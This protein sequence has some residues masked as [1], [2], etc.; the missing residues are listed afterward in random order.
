[1][2]FKIT[3]KKSILKDL[4]FLCLGLILGV[5]L[6]KY[7]LPHIIT[8]SN[9]AV[10]EGGYNFINPLLSCN[11]SEDKQFSSYK[12]IEDKL[13]TYI[14]QNIKNGDA[15]NISVY[16][17]GLNS[18]HWSGVGE[19]NTYAPAS[20]LK[21]PLMIAYLKEADDNPDILKQKLTYTQTTDE[22]TA[23]YFKPQKF[24][25]P[26][27]SYTVDDLL[28]YMI[29][30]SDNNAATLLQNNLKQSDLLEVYSDIGIPVSSNLTDENM[31]PKIYSYIFRILYNATYLSKPM[32]QYALEL[33]SYADF[34]QGLESGV[35]SNM[36]TSNKFG[37]RTVETKNPMTG[38]LTVDYREL[39]DCG[40]IYYPKNP[41]LLCIMTKG[42]DF[43][44]LTKIISDIS[45][46]VYNE[47]TNGV[48]KI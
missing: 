17:R 4:S 25:L 3:T 42:Q 12:P 20:L 5:L 15:K 43:S 2:F 1:M 16:F 8:D 34:P 46:M 45:T 10:R 13:R 36:P 48:L 29:L 40:I 31:S 22:N 39:H 44:K 9:Y 6:Q 18:G 28:H 24:I 14:N 23:E 38:D 19:N 37:E 27:Q 21:V 30:Y 7:Y 47:T 26:N 32:S 33:L 35:P 11:I 41:Y